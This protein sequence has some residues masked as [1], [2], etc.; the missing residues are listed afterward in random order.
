MIQNRYSFVS[1]P[2]NACMGERLFSFTSSVAANKSHAGSERAAVFTPSINRSPS[3][4]CMM[5]SGGRAANEQNHF[6]SFL[7]LLATDFFF[8][9][10]CKACLSEWVETITVWYSTSLWGVLLELPQFP[11]RVYKIIMSKKYSLEV[12]ISFDNNVL[13]KWVEPLNSYSLFAHKIL[14]LREVLHPSTPFFFPIDSILKMIQIYF[15][16]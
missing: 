2:N 4:S 10:C 13:I 6:D 15:N 14:N 12:R 1:C 16:V 7:A 3:S 5:I 8:S 11:G 9:L